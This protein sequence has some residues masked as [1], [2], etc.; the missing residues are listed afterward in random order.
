M[1]KHYLDNI[2]FLTIFFVVIFHVYFYYNNIGTEAMFAGLKPYEGA[3]T[4]AGIYQYFV[5]PWFM[6]LLFVVAGIS[7]RYALEKRT[8][9]QFLKERVDKILAPSTLGV[10][11]FG[12][13]GGYVIYLHTARGNM[14][15]SVPAFVRVI[16]ILCCGIGALWFCHV[17]FVAALFLLLIRKIAGKCNAAYHVLPERHYIPAFLAGY[18][19]FS[20]ESV[21]EKIKNA[22]L[23]L[24]ICA[25]VSGIF[26]IVRCYGMAYT[27]KDVLSRWDLNLYAFFMVLLVLGAGPK[28]LDFS[29]NFTN[30]MR[31]CCFGIYVLHIPVLL[32]INYLLAGKELPL[33]VVYGIELVGGF[34][35]SILLYE[36]IRRIPVLRYWILGIRKQRNNV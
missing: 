11:A 30:Y 22:V 8:E 9:R 24:G 34:V 32:V 12:W 2:R 10:L 3:V 36:V 16:I 35:V 28:W 17:L 20:N 23:L 6:L 27:D 4:F 15:E 26:Y 29:N 13:L 18:Y 21:M 5:Y 1:R 7:A 19:L 14:P 31:K 25:A 33:T